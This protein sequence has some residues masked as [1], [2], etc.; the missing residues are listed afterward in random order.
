[1]ASFVTGVTRRRRSFG[2]CRRD[3]RH[4]LQ[5]VYDGRF[6]RV[7]PVVAQV[8]DQFLACGGLVVG[9]VACW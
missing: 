4:R 2:G 1:M 7:R 9:C 6:A 5:T 3:H 8:A